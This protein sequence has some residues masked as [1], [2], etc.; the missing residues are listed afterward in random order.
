MMNATPT[1]ETN[2]ARYLLRYCVRKKSDC[3]CSPCSRPNSQMGG[4]MKNETTYARVM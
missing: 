4:R 3:V 1:T 2:A